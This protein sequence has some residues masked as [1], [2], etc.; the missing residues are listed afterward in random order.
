MMV[1]GLIISLLAGN[2]TLFSLGVFLFNAGFRGFYNASLLT[3]S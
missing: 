3:L 1:V 2:V